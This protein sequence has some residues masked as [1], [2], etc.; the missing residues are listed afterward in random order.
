ML[1][2]GPLVVESHTP[3]RTLVLE[4]NHPNPFNPTTTIRFAVNEPGQVALRIFNARGE[5]VGTLVDAPHG[6]GNFVVEWNGQDDAGVAA[7]SGVY[8]AQ[9]DRTEERRRI[10]M[11][12][13]R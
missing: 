2:L 12:L 8:Y 3:D 9:L 4:Q 5:L 11:T 13:V 1:L 7:S 6:V 10:K